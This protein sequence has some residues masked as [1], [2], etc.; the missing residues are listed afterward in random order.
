MDKYRIL[1][2]NRKKHSFLSSFLLLLKAQISHSFKEDN[3]SQISSEAMG[4]DEG[5][6]P[7]AKWIFLTRGIS[8]LV[9]PSFSITC[10]IT[11]CSVKNVLS[12]VSAE[13]LSKA[14]LTASI[15]VPVVWLSVC[16]CTDWRELNTP[17]ST[18]SCMGIA[19]AGIASRCFS[20]LLSLHPEY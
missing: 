9:P 13:I 20:S 19:A 12:I 11:F 10:S 8:K 4:N 16:Y 5:C 2:A 6:A 1:L 15:S 7:Q 14:L 3:P 18:H 17:R